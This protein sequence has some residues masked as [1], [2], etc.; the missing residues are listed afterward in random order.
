MGYLLASEV[1]ALVLPI[2]FT[3][4]SEEVS[5]ANIVQAVCFE[6]VSIRCLL[7]HPHQ[8]ICQSNISSGV[9]F[10]KQPT[11]KTHLFTLV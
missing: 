4:K 7:F 3:V 8:T 9:R 1:P 5:F 10:R 2:V 6:H 11:K